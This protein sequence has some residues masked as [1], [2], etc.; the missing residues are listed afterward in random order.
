MRSLILLPLLAISLHAA[1]VSGAWSGT[2][3]L[4]DPSTGNRIEAPVR[5]VLQQKGDA[6]TVRITRRNTEVEAA[7]EGKLSG[8]VLTFAVKASSDGSAFNFRLVLDGSGKLAGTVEGML[9]S[10]K[11]NG[12]VQLTR[13]P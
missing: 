8:D 4:A 2:V 1:D 3:E 5:A 10:G 11:I 9:D 13:Q 6:V 12:K 7:G